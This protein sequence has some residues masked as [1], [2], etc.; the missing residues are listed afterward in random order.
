MTMTQVVTQLLFCKDNFL[1]YT[2]CHSKV[3]NQVHCMYS[4]DIILLI[5]L[6]NIII[7]CKGIRSKFD[8]ILTAETWCDHAM[9]PRESP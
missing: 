1:T 7:V 3:Y 5:Y 4:N 9:L 8:G 6:D 2:N